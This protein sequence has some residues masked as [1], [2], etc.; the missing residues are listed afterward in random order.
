MKHDLT[1]VALNQ[2]QIT[3]AKEVKSLPP[4]EPGSAAPGD[5][6]PAGK[7]RG[8]PDKEAEGCGGCRVGWKS[9]RRLSHRPLGNSSEGVSHTPPAARTSF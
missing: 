3:K 2:E 4:S 7:A 5:R 8:A 9:P 1:L 6:S